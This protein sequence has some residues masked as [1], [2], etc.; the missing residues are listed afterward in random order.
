MVEIACHESMEPV[1]TALTFGEAICNAGR[2]THFDGLLE[3]G[4]RMDARVVEGT[5][6]ENRRA[7]TYRGFESLSIRCGNLGGFRRVPPF[8]VFCC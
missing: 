1:L 6:L 3:W 7:E 2:L 8:A 5:G 4:A